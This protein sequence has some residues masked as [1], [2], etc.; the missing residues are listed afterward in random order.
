MKL[1]KKDEHFLIKKLNGFFQK[2]DW[3]YLHTIKTAKF[4]KKIC[5]ETGTNEK[6]LM[7][8]A[9][10]HDIG[11]SKLI[12]KNYSLKERINAKKEHMEIGAKLAEPILRKLN[13]SKEEIKEV[14]RLIK[15]HD[16]LNNLKEENDFLIF[17]ADSL[18]GLATRENSAF[19]QTE[20]NQYIKIFKR[21]R[22]P[23]IKSNFGK[24]EVVKLLNKYKK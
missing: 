21:K 3:N 1:N 13:Y 17:E 11:Y 16:K 19:T 5:D 2:D 23:L 8:T 12:K 4:M 24:K 10:L 20:L 7:T 14:L 18:G 9:Y 6:I 22:L 15:V